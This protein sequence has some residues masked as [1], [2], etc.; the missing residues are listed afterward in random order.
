MIPFRF[1]SLILYISKTMLKEP[2]V[3]GSNRLFIKSI[4]HQIKL[5]LAFANSGF[6]HLERFTHEAVELSRDRIFTCS[7]VTI[8]L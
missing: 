4:L 8:K 1:P 5:H 3:K 6:K 7:L 2:I